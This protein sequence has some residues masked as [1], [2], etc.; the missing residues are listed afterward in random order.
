[1]FSAAVR[2]GSRLNDWNTKPS[3]S[4]RSWVSWRSL[5][6]LR[7]TSPRT[8]RPAVSESSPAMQCRSVDLPDPDGPITAVKR[9]AGK[10][11]DTSSR[12]R[13]VVSPVP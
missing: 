2:V 6:L 8:I 11:T 1:M 9:P 5:S 4:R 10:V 3:R 7:S 13:T 12:A